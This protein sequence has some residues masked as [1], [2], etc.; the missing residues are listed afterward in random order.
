MKIRN[1]LIVAMTSVVVAMMVIFILLI[2]VQFFITRD[3]SYLSNKGEILKVEEFMVDYYEKS[4]SW[5]GV[6]KQEPPTKLPFVLLDREGE[7]LW[8]SGD[9][10]QDIIVDIAFPATLNITEQKIGKLYVLTPTQY[11]VYVNKNTWDKYMYGIIGLASLIVLVFAFFLILMISRTLTRPIHVL[12]KRIQAFEKGDSTIEFQM[13]RKDEFKQIGDALASMK[14][15]IEQAEEA[16]KTLVSDIAHEL[17]TPLTVIQGEIELLH[18]QQRKVSEEKFASIS[19]E[20]IRLTCIIEDI[21]LLSKIEAHQVQLTKQKIQL[22]DLFTLLARKTQFLLEQQEVELILPMDTGQSVWGDEDKILQVLY[23]LV[24]NALIHGRTTK[25]VII[26]AR[27][28]SA[29]T[30]FSVT[31]DGIGISEKDRQFIFERF[32][33]GDESRSRKTGGTGIGLSIVKAYVEMHEGKIETESHSGI[34]TTF[35]IFLPNF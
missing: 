29:E 23:N 19:S 32:Y 25:K 9:I 13:A 16:R 3:L 30:I 34:G 14:Q 20:I 26:E 31:D 10:A 11:Q 35:I 28:T 21:L 4:R 17:K 33:R 22:S 5:E 6:S 7:L 27:H 2:Q 8:S 24:N 18:I 12:T 1:K 15:H